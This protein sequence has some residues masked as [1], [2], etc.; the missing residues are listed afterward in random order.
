M[1][2]PGPIRGVMGEVIPVHGPRDPAR[3]FGDMTGFKTLTDLA[4]RIGTDAGRRNAVVWISGGLNAPSDALCGKGRGDDFQCGALAA[5]LESMRR[6]N[7]AAYPIFTGDFSARLMKEVADASGGFVMSAANFDR[8]LPGLIDDLDHYYLIGFYPDDTSDQKFHAV[9]VRM[10][11]PGLTVRYRRG[12]QPGAPPKPRNSSGLARMSEGLL[13]VMDLPLRITGTALP[14]GSSVVVSLEVRTDRAAL[15]EG[16]GH[17]RDALRYQ[18][19]AVDL[20]KKKP[21]TTIAREARLDLNPEEAKAAPGDP[22]A[23]Q[24]H[25]SL[26]LGPGRYQLRASAQSGKTKKGGSVFHEIEVP[27]FKRGPALSDIVIG[28]DAGGRVPILR[29]GTG[30]ARLPFAPTLDRE[31]SADDGLLVMCEFVQRANG[32]ADVTIELLRASGEPL[33]RLV[34][35]RVSGADLAR[36]DPKLP[37]QGL[38]PGGYLL[39]VTAVGGTFSTH[40]EVGFVVK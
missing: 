5:L 3:F 9:D 1:P 33:R 17:L 16:D 20:R 37:L 12:Y 29:G 32:E 18:V 6:A 30:V 21:V 38:Q 10:N 34:T 4:K 8:E 14:G 28:Y 11:R 31:F 39:R 13:P 7:V 23:H 15:V 19:W 27:D 24:I 2:D 36:L 25:T 26:P 22:L 40:R 35:R